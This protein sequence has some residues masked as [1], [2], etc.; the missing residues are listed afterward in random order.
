MVTQPELEILILILILILISIMAGNAESWILVYKTHTRAEDL[1][2]T[3][4]IAPSGQDTTRYTTKSLLEVQKLHL[5]SDA[6]H[7]C[8]STDTG[9]YQVRQQD[10]WP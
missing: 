3:S 5:F 7:D 6:S 8:H 9:T 4:G 10:P 2:K 1:Y